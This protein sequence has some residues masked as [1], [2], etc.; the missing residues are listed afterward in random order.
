MC[1]A[2]RFELQTEDTWNVY[3]HCE[4]CRKHSGAPVTMLVT[5]SP[6]QVDWT[7]G[8]RELY[9]STPGRYRA[10]CRDCGTSLT[11]EA[12]IA[13]VEHPGKLVNRGSFMAIHI[14][15]FDHPDD[16]VPT[17]HTFVGDALPWFEIKD[18]LP[19]HQG[20]KY[21]TAIR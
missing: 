2:V 17:E 13:N 19:R 3:C 4:S 18:E 8:E 21:I 5:V 9:E 16:F 10:F 12:E 20:S 11:W 6:N 1:G 7:K 14:S 15:T